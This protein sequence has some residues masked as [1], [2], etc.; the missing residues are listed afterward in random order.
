VRVLISS[1]YRNGVPS[2]P[3]LTFE[4]LSDGRSVRFVHAA[5]CGRLVVQCQLWRRHTS[6]AMFESFP[7]FQVL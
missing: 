1:S 2:F 3:F 5:E 4:T 7:S 6:T